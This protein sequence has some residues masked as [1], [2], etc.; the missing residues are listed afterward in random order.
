MTAGNW[1]PEL[2]EIAGGKN[3]Q[4]EHN[5]HSPWLDWSK[6]VEADPD[7]L[8]FMPCGWSISR[9]REELHWITNRPEWPALN[10]VR[11]GRVFLVD[12]HHYFNRPGFNRP[13]PRLIDSS[14]DSVG[15]SA[16]WPL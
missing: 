12:G 8:I 4:S 10:A 14:R 7:F 5:Q 16:F 11:S 13:G 6:L 2:V 15:D 1:V 9:A 3:V